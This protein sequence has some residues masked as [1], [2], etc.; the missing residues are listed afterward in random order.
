MIKSGQVG[1]LLNVTGAEATRNAQQLAVEISKLGIPLL[2]GYDVIHD[3]RTM[4]PIPLAEATSWE[5]ELA[6]RSSMIAAL[7]ATAAGVHWTFA[8]M[9]DIARDARW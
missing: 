1:S 2:F 9:V 3:Y 7:E 6:E 5:P 8:P 4:F